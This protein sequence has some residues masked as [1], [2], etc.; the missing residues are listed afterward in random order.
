M[1]RPV[2]RVGGGHVRS[3]VVHGHGV[4]LEWHR[5]PGV[6]LAQIRGQGLRS[7]EQAILQAAVQAT[8]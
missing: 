7:R 2:I 5:R 4:V 8:E 6:V 3:V 1:M